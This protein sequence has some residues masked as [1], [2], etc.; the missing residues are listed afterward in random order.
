MWIL[1]LRYWAPGGFIIM[2]DDGSPLAREPQI[3]SLFGFFDRRNE[4][5][6]LAVWL[7]I[8]GYL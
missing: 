6:W 2:I 7:M 8:V 1:L 5:M 4:M 3:L